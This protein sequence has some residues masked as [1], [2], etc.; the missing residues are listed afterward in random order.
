[1]DDKAF[2]NI[3]ERCYCALD[4]PGGL[5]AL[6]RHLGTV[7]GAD[8]GDI[9][10]EDRQGGAIRTHGS[11][12]FDPAFLASYDAEFLGENPWL[13]SLTRHPAG[14]VR[15]DIEDTPGFR[16]SA[17][18]NDWVR[19]QKLDRSLGAVLPVPGRGTTWVGFARAHGAPAFGAERAVLQRLLPHLTRS[20][21]LADRLALWA[22]TSPLAMLEGPTLRLE[23]SGRLVE[24]NAAGRGY[25]SGQGLVLT[26][27]GMLEAVNRADNR[28][29]AHAIR[30]VAD[31]RPEARSARPVCLISRDEDLPLVVRLS[32]WHA[33]AGTRAGAGDATGVLLRLRDA[34]QVGADLDLRPLAMAYRL[35]RTELALLRWLV[36]GGRVDE[37]AG[38]RG[39]KPSTARWH[40]KNAETKTG[41]TRSEQLVSLAFRMGLCSTG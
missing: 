13:D 28:A 16:D 29:L 17:Y 15:D 2:L 6:T 11:F 9:V 23:P 34:A 39:M 37:F 12:G 4:A 26:R 35:T 31:D 36:S 41:T 10:T 20:I 25:L 30:T 22:Q 7:L 32:A 19:P 38:A 5:Q 27:G 33:G 3:V 40:L 14:V 21:T 8:A 1:M 18:Y 24:A